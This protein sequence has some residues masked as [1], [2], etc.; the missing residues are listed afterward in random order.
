MSIIKKLH[1][2]APYMF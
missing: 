2:N 1:K